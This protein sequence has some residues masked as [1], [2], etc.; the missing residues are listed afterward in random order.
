MTLFDENVSVVP[1][2]RQRWRRGTVVGVWSLTIAV[3]VL[4]VMT[5]LPSAYVIQQPGPV[6]N[7]LGTTAS[8]DGQQVPLI[9]CPTRRTPPVPVSSTC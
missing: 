5:F 6:Y 4:F 9:T 7:T 1:A 2:P 8:A 3:I